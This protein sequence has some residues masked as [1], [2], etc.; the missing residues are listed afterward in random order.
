MHR[1]T[2]GPMGKSR[3]CIP[4]P[5]AAGKSGCQWQGV[6]GGYSQDY[7]TETMEYSICLGNDEL[8]AVTP[9]VTNARPTFQCRRFE[10]IGKSRT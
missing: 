7:M 3:Q 6:M 10:S 5:L 9:N 2:C 8:P 1:H 4:A